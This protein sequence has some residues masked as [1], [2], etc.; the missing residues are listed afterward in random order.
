LCL[1]LYDTKSRN[2]NPSCAVMK[3]RLWC[4]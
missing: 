1:S 4:G 3:L 2:V